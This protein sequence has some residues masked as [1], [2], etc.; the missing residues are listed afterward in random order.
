[1]EEEAFAVATAAS[2]CLDGLFVESGA[3]GGGNGGV[4]KWRPPPGRLLK[5]HQP[6]EEVSGDATSSVSSDEPPSVSGVELADDTAKNESSKKERKQTCRQPRVA[7][8]TKS[9]IDHLEDGYRWRKYGQKAIKN[10]PFPRSYYRCTNTK[11]QVK[12]R[13]ERSYEDPSIVIT[14]YEGQHCHYT[15]SY[16]RPIFAALHLH[17]AIT[18]HHFDPPLA[19]SSPRVFPPSLQFYHDNHCSD[20]AIEQT[21]FHEASLNST[22]IDEGLLG[23]IVPSTLRNR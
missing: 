20:Q 15:I 6:P 12:K 7:F 17:N 19:L 8:M 13:V 16:P 1:M 9:E 3:I 22:S 4:A 11:C 18:H 14:T 2:A 23:D 5:G 21:Q 10:S